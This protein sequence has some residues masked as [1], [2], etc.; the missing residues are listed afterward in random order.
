MRQQL[1]RSDALTG[2]PNRRSDDEQLQEIVN[3]SARYGHGFTVMYFDVDNFKSIND[4]QGHGGGDD[5]LKEI[6]L[7]LLASVRETDTVSRLAGD[8]FTI[9]LD[10]ITKQEDAASMADKI[11]DAIRKPFL[12]AASAGRFR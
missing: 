5:V 7:R 8:E 6:A 4:T 9:I 12:I 10:E 3:R 2:L 1:A 11:L